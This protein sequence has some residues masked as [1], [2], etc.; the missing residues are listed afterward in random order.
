MEL[1]MKR[2]SE[3]K[4]NNTVMSIVTQIPGL[5]RSWKVV[6]DLR[7]IRGKQAH[8]YL[9]LQSHIVEHPKDFVAR[10]VCAFLEHRMDADAFD[11]VKEKESGYNDILSNP[12]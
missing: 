2:F 10:G 7:E 8:K 6:T 4:F 5:E 9:R 1:R 11:K 3:K 12:D